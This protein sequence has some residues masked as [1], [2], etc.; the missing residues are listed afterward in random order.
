VRIVEKYGSD[1]KRI[2]QDDPYR[3]V[4]DI[5]GYGFKTVDEIALELKFLTNSKERI[6]AGVLHTMRKLEEKGHT[7]GTEA[8]ILEKATKLLSLEPTIIRQRIH[9]LDETERPYGILAYDQNQEA[10]GSAYQLP[11]TAETERCIAEAIAHIW[12]TKSILPAIEIDAIVQWEKERAGFKLADQQTTALRNAL[13]AKVSVITGG[14]GTGKT[15]IL[16]AMVDILRSKGARICLA[17]PTGRAAQQLAEATGEP[18]STIHRLLKYTFATRKL[19]RRQPPA[20]RFSHTRRNEHARHPARGTPFPGHPQ[21]FPHT[22]RGR[23]RPATQ[24]PCR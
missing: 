12:Q 15:T 7:L 11:A 20:L 3:L 17:S 1:A 14:P 23:C 10:L 16:R 24:R 8:M 2:V 9:A 21:R 13:A 22:P 4:E 6:D 5:I 18:A 19:Q